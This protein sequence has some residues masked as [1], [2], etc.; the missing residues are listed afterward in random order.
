MDADAIAT[1]RRF[2]RAVAREIGALELSYLGQGRPLGSARVL[3]VIG[4]AGRDLVEL[5]EELDLDAGLLSRL[6][7]GLAR[8]GLIGSPPARR[9]AAAAAPPGPRPAAPRPRATTPAPTSAPP[10]SWPRRGAAPTA[11]SPRWTSSP[12]R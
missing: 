9:T 6:L 4:A 5:R 10:A 3:C 1:I 2:N 7:A 12:P 8:E 11:S